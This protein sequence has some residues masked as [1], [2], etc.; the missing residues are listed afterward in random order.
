MGLFHLLAATAKL[1]LMNNIDIDLFHKTFFNTSSI[2]WH[3]CRKQDSIESSFPDIVTA[4]SV[5]VGN[6]SD[7]TCTDAPVVYK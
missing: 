3:I 1:Y 4:R 7:A 6:I 2:I 5:D